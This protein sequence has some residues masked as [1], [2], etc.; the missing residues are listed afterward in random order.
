M[1]TAADTPDANSRPDPDPAAT[2]KP[3]RAALLIALVRRLIDYGK[4]LAA[5]LQQRGFTADL[6]NTPLAF[7]TSDIARILACITRGLLR[8]SALEARIVRSAAFLDAG[9]RPQKLPTLRTP[10]PPAAPAAERH[11]DD[12]DPRLAC[13]P[14]PEQIADEA[15]RRPIGAVIADI[16]RDLGIMP[17]HKLWRDLQLVII[18]YGGNIA[19]LLKDM[20]QRPRL[21]FA[22]GWRIGPPP[23]S[24]AFA[25][26]PRP[27]AATGPP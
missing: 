2:A 21:A 23:A 24:P 1:S 22:A 9:P 8:A 15:R 5:S 25:N 3:G 14:T 10:R 17:N 4:E 13:L 18:E 27:C 7:G 6:I 19:T 20:F 11:A 16:C 12:G 26:A